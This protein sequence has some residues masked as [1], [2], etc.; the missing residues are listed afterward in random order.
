VKIG[1]TVAFCN[2]LNAG[3]EPPQLKR[4]YPLVPTAGI[5]VLS[6]TKVLQFVWRTG[7]GLGLVIDGNVWV[8][9]CNAKT[10]PIAAI[11]TTA[12]RIACFVVGKRIQSRAVVF[13][14]Y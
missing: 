9:T 1:A 6:A 13:R 11:I 3:V 5:V 10:A 14:E 7:G 2:I 12:P 4:T 8:N